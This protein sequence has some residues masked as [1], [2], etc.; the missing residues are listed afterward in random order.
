M[1]MNVLIITIKINSDIE[2]IW[3]YNIDIVNS[4][5]ISSSKPVIKLFEYRIENK[6][7]VNSILEIAC[8]IIYK[9]ANYNDVG[10]S[11]HTYSLMDTNNNLIHV[12]N[13]MHTNSGDNLANHLNMNDDF[14]IL[15][16]NGHTDKMKIELQIS[17]IDVN[18][19]GNIG[20]RIMNPYNNNILC[21]KHIKYLSEK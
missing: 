18:R 6:F 14:R 9:Y 19:S 17:K 20:F 1:I 2:N 7:T 12:H 11:R 4:Y 5:T 8:N 21:I 10:L 13:I 15:F 3:F 16:K